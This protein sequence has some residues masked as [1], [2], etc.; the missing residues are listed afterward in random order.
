MLKWLLRFL[1]SRVEYYP[2]NTYIGPVSEKEWNALLP[3]L[4]LG[5]DKHLPMFRALQIMLRRVE[6]KLHEQPPVEAVK[7]SEWVESRKK[8]AVEAS[9]L[10]F[11]LRLPI[12]A[13]ERLKAVRKK[14]EADKK[15]KESAGI[16]ADD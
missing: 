7:L 9:V 2:E 6:S 1:P 8:L 13:N 15:E 16:P 4:A 12:M 5:Y 11:M 14:A 3:E 10:T